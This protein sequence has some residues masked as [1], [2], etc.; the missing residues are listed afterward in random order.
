MSYLQVIL[1]F[2]FLAAASPTNAANI[3]EISCSKC[4]Y[5]K[6]LQTG[7]TKASSTNYSAYFCSDP[8]NLLSIADSHSNSQC[9]SKLT[10]F[11]LKDG[12]RPQFPICKKG[13][14]HVKHTI[15]A[16]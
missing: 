6:T 11:K 15:T 1:T 8:A 7:R 12:D 3:Y 16:C 10:P 4:G 2:I 14:L 5:T 9:K 13:Y